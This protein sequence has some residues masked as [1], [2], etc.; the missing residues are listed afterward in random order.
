MRHHCSAG[1][2]FA[3]NFYRHWA[4]IILR[5]PGD[6]PLIP[7][8]REGVTHGDPPLMVMYGITLAPLAEELMDIDPTLLSPF[9][10]N[11]AAFDR[12]AQ[13]SVLQLRLMMD[14]GTEQGYF[15]KPTKSLFIADNLEEKESAKS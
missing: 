4:Q 6:A 11:D 10:A 9:Y 14:R 15:P 8:I 7:L 12:S 13:Q 2:R 1:A 3:F 5:Q